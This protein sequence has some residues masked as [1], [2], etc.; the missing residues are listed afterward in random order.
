MVETDNQNQTPAW[1]LFVDGS[2]NEHNAGAGLILITPEG[3][4]FHCAIIFNFTSPNNEVE[5]EALLA[6]LRLAKGMN[7]KSLEIYSD[8]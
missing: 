3:H 6:G 8:S 5:Y 7:I 1:K 2:S 4:W